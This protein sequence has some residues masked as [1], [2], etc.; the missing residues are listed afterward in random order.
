M[1]F[2]PI[3]TAERI[4]TSQRAPQHRNEGTVFGNLPLSQQ[5]HQWDTIYPAIYV[6]LLT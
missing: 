3:I 5:N 6:Y 4:H 1:I 2:A